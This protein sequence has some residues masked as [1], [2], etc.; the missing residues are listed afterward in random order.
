[1]QPVDLPGY[2]RVTGTAAA[3]TTILDRAGNV[4]RVIMTTS[5]T[6]TA[7]FYDNASGTS[8]ATHLYEISNFIDGTADTVRELG[9]KV[10]NGLTVAV[11]GTTDFVVVY[12]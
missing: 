7:I 5:A 8:A 1:M 4:H 9:H 10:K 3:N 11:S 6:G 2:T 12:H